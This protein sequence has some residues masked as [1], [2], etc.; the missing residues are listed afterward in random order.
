E[1][2][3]FRIAAPVVASAKHGHMFMRLPEPTALQLAEAPLLPLGIRII[4]GRA[5]VLRDFS[6]R[7]H[8]LQGAELLSVNGSATQDLV[9]CLGESYS[10]DAGQLDARDR[11][12]SGLNFNI[13]LISLMSLGPPYRIV[14]NQ[15][16]TKFTKVLNGI[17]HLEAQWRQQYPNDY[18][19]RKRGEMR[20][21]FPE[22]GIALLRIPHWDY[23][24]EKHSPSADLQKMMESIIDKKASALIIDIRDNGGGEEALGSQLLAYLMSEPFP[25]YKCTVFKEDHFP[26]L[27]YGVG[28][29]ADYGKLLP[30]YIGPVDENCRIYGNFALKNRPNLGIQQPRSPHFDGA[31]FVIVNAGGFSTSVEFAAHVHSEHRGILIGQPPHGSYWSNDSGITPTIALPNSGLLVDIPLIHY[32]HSLRNNVPIGSP[33]PIDRPVQLSIKSMIASD[34]PEMD[35]ALQLARSAVKDFSFLLPK[36]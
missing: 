3:F 1:I 35:L 27:L 33:V 11:V 4:D 26:W 6:S 8:S 19:V 10:I 28:E 13:G 22:K 34:D 5:Y 2:D 12:I 31:V 32:Q 30:E 20:V 18:E 29:S 21:E 9:A 36:S 23:E 24:E 17:A 14:I 25:Y 15:N 7:E 16:G